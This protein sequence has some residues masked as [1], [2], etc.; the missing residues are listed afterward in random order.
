M[1]KEDLLELF[2]EKATS[3]NRDYD[4]LNPKYLDDLA[5]FKRLDEEKKKKELEMI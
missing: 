5:R 3:I 4:K 2:P 1:T